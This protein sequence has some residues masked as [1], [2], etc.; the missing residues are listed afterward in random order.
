MLS[1]STKKSQ[2]SVGLAPN[3]PSNASAGKL[4]F[5]FQIND[6]KFGTFLEKCQ[7]YWIVEFTVMSAEATIAHRAPKIS[8]FLGACPKLPRKAPGLHLN[9]WIGMAVGEVGSHSQ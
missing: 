7:K 5:F 1:Y 6:H 4:I 2:F 3:P 9:W 8:I